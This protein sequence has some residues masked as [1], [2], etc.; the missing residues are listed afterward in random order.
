VT[1]GDPA[2]EAAVLDLG[3]LAS[4]SWRLTVIAADGTRAWTNP[5][6]S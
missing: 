1:E 4:P 6:W 5:V 3:K 2:L